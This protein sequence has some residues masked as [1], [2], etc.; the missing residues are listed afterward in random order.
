MTKLFDVRPAKFV[1]QI[2]CD[3]CGTAAQHSEHEIEN[4]LGIE[5]NA[6]WD[7]SLGDGTRAELDLC[8]ACVRTVLGPW[9]RLSKQG[10]AR[11]VDW[12]KFFAEKP[13]AD[14]RRPRRLGPPK[15]K[16]E[17]ADTPD[18][19]PDDGARPPTTGKPRRR[20]KVSK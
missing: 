4:F 5:I 13:E 15:G 10:W 11:P 16:S 12:K 17:A 3:R 1:W 19:A 20:R 6:G 9:L 18:R 8:H 2:R 7:S 14:V